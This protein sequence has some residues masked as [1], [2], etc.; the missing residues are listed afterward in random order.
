MADDQTKDDDSAFEEESQ[1]EKTSEEEIEDDSE[2]KDEEPKN[3]RSEIAQKKHWREK[4]QKS[5]Q[6]VSELET[7]LETL[8][9]AV[10]K[11]DDEKE[12][13]AQEYIRKQAR[14][15]F[16]ELQKEK[17]KDEA[18]ELAD[19]EGKVQDILDEN[20]DVSEE[21]LLDTIEEL[22]VEPAVALK[23][24]QRQPKGREEKKPRMPTARRASPDGDSGKKPDDS[25]K[26][27]FQ[28]AQEEISKLKG[29]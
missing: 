2:K 7:E 4:A 17:A 6:R 21:E 19:F 13:A 9:S 26:S 24:L 10:K 29:K 23:I 8:K 20:P 11:P 25:R 14:Q 16:D 1:E 27:I 18:K 15:V 5:S 22:E 3:R 12:A 28:I